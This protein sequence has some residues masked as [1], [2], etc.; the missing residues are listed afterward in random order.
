LPR[1]PSPELLEAK[2]VTG[3]RPAGALEHATILLALAGGALVLV[4][5]VIVSVSVVRRWFTGDGVPGDFEIVQTGLAVAIFAFLPLCQL[6]NAN[7][8]VDTFTMR[9]PVRVQAALDGLW[10]L[11]YAAVALLIAWQTALGAMGTIASG[12]TSMVLGL[13]IGWAMVLA[14]IFAFWLTLVTVVTALRALRGARA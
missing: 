9:L 8:I 13:P 2:P 6:H 4:F 7:I 1:G 14:S 11:L 3:S 5:A 12:T 10:A